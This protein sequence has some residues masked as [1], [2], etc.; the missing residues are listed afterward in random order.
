MFFSQ[1]PIEEKLDAEITTLLASM[2]SHTDKTDSEY[3]EMTERFK[4]L[5]ELR[6]TSRISPDTIAT[7]AANI[8]G[9]AV[10]MN[11][12]RAHVIASKAFTLVKKMF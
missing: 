12:E 10:V 4:T 7:I 1:N 8:I 9:L 5:M 11:H 6:N 2:D 3:K